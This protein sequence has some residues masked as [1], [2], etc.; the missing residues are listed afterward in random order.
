MLINIDIMAQKE[1]QTSTNYTRATLNLYLTVY[2]EVVAGKNPAQICRKYNISKSKLNYYIAS[3]KRKGL[4]R[5]VGY[6][7]WQST[8]IS[9]KKFPTE[10][11]KGWSKSFIMDEV[12]KKPEECIICYSKEDI[13]NHHPTS[14]SK[15]TVPLCRKHHLEVHGKTRLSNRKKPIKELVNALKLSNSV[16]GH[17]FQFKLKIP[18]IHN[19]PNRKKYLDKRNIPYKILKVF[20]GGQRIMFRNKK[21]WL[22]PFSIIVYEKGSFWGNISWETRKR[23]IKSFLDLI[24]ALERY[25][26]IDFQNHN[27]YDFKVCKQHYSLVNNELAKQY[28]KEHRKLYIKHYGKLWAL[29]DNSYHLNEFETL[30]PKTAPDDEVLVQDFFNTIKEDKKQNIINHLKKLSEEGVLTNSQ[31]AKLLLNN[32]NALLTIVKLLDLPEHIL[33]RNISPSDKRKHIDSA[34]TTYIG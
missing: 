16:R 8:S 6:G 7:T 10:Y 13:E 27:R 23:A 30:H 12:Q 14:K 9:L 22:L 20:G 31:L 4:I 26:H 11:L 18:K 29:I 5:K 24:K 25:L 19:W 3:L 1:V 33:E 34:L 28:N 2:Q 15:N 32:Q 17:G 21:I